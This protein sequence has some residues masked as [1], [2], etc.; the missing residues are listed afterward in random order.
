MAY[1][2]AVSAGMA[3]GIQ[4]RAAECTNKGRKTNPKCDELPASES[5]AVDIGLRSD[6]GPS[7]FVCGQAVLALQFHT[8]MLSG[9]LI[10]FVHTLHL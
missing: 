8:W 10:F 1:N 9:P 6:S 5:A 7:G 3:E 2:I 4:P